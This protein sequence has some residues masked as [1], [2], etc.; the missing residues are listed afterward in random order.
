MIITPFTGDI[1]ETGFYDFF[2][3]TMYDESHDMLRGLSRSFFRHRQNV[4]V[5]F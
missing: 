5:F 1:L 4:H 2:E 3:S